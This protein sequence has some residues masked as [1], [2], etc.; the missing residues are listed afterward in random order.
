MA[1]LI[2][3][4]VSSVLELRRESGGS[5]GGDFGEEAAHPEVEVSP[6]LE[7]AARPEAPKVTSRI[8]ENLLRIDETNLSFLT[9][10]ITRY[11][12]PLTGYSGALR[13]AF[14]LPGEE[15]TRFV[16]D[17]GLRIRFVDMS[18]KEAPAREGRVPDQPG[19]YRVQFVKGRSIANID[20]FVAIVQIPFSAKTE[21]KLNGYMLGTWPFENGGKPRTPAY[22]NPAGFVEVTPANRNVPISE[23]FRLGDFLTKGQDSTW[24]KYMVLSSKLI[25]KLELVI[26]G[27]EQRGVTVDRMRIMSGFRHPSYNAGG[28]NTAGRA[29]LSRHMYGDASDVFIDNNADNWSDDITGD[30]RLTI[31][32]AERI[33]DIVDEIERQYPS[34]V[35]GV[36]IYPACCGHGPMTHVDVRGNRARWYY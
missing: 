26:D 22:A 34:L 7:A 36:G 10:A 2:A 24:P 29:S 30:G 19:V 13:A 5:R 4:W 28:G 27:L 32:D 16:R 31:R 11:Q 15:M 8:T 33:R 21:G 6:S 23:H 20:D 18:N 17:P 12:T 3:G 14:Y 9:S 25:D 1:I 35:G